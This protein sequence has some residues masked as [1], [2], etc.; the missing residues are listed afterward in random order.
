[1]VDSDQDQKT[2]EASDKRIEDAREK[3]QLAVSK[4]MSTWFVFVAILM[5]VAWFGPPLGAK[6]V[7]ALRVFLERPEQLYLEGAGLQ[8]LLAGVFAHVALAFTGVFGVLFVMSMIG[9]MIQTGFYVNP[10]NIKVDPA[11]VFALQGMKKLFSMDS[12]VELLKSIAKLVIM[13]YIA[14]R[15]LRPI[16]MEVPLSV[17]YAINDTLHYLHEKSIRLVAI[18]MILITLIAVVDWLYVR[19]KYFKGLRMT[20]QEVKDEHKQ[21]EGDPFVKGR[22]RRIRMERSR[23]RMMAAVPEANV[24]VTNPTH[25]AVALKYDQF[26][27]SAPIVLAKGPDLIA[28]RIREVAEEHDI[29]LVSN[30][31][32]ARALYDTAE[33]DEPINPEHYRAVAEVISY[34]FKL[35]GKPNTKP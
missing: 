4:E 19:F 26:S 17:N 2:E 29:P 5:I 32:L 24:V 10:T 31:P 22:L 8:G 14:Y 1:M 34:V 13:G 30:P 6:S 33:I 28:L 21:M 27:M 35:K 18:L 3:G 16:Y 12:I 15:V 9:T 20:K 11:K 23:Q 7:S 25:Y